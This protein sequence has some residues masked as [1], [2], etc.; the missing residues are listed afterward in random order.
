[1]KYLIYLL[2]IGCIASCSVF[3]SDPGEVETEI[4]ESEELKISNHLERSIYYA[5]IERDMA[6]VANLAL[7]SDEENEIKSQEHKIIPLKDIY[8]YEAGKE[9]LLYYWTATDPTTEDVQSK[10]IDTN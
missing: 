10:V 5:V 6:A 8:G 9:V 3:N 1:M 2:M 4:T 7:T